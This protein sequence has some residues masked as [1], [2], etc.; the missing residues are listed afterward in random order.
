[1]VALSTDKAC[2]PINFYGATKLCS[3]KLFI[4]GNA[5][6]GP[7]ETKFSVVRYGNIAGSRGSV[8]PFF[9]KLIEFGAKELPITDLRM[10][11]FWTKFE[12]AAEMVMTALDTMYGGEL[13][14]RKAPS[15]KIT[16]LAKAIA[17]NIPIKIIGIRPG[18]KIHE[19][20][21]SADDSRKAIE[22]DNYYIIQ[23]DFSWWN[24]KRLHKEGKKVAADFEYQSGNNSQWLTIEQ[25]QKL[26]QE[27]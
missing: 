2:A 27:I 26:I 20:M 23:P 19:M 9:K 22:L 1:V 10:S 21:I 15:V 8:I 11:R 13:F 5:Y 17:P 7:H 24:K 12:D 25:I 16:D 3:D 6:V 14:V 18:E 4:S